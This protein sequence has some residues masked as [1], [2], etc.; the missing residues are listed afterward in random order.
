MSTL[1]STLIQ[2]MRPSFLLLTPACILAGIGAAG[3]EGA[4]DWGLA[5]WVLL[6][7][8]AAHIS[9]NMLNEY[10]D[11]KSGLDLHTARTPFSGG[12]GAL[13]A[14]PEALSA[15][16]WG[17][18]IALLITII[19]GCFLIQLRGWALL[20]PGLLGCAIVLT[21]TQWI[22]KMP[23]LC[24]ITPGLGFGSLMVMGTQLV[25]T[26]H[27]SIP[28][29]LV[30]LVPFFLVNNLLLLNQFPDKDADSRA[31]RRHLLIVYGD[32]AAHRIFALFNLCAFICVISALALYASLPWSLLAI[33]PALPAA[34]ATWRLFH[35]NGDIETLKPA[36]ARNVIVNL[37][38]PTLLGMALLLSR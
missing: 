7:A 36:M 8:I 30:S 6:A 27:Y 19:V 1:T 31:G 35:F 26:G 5:A 24:L 13:P 29:L 14:M 10:F 28:A 11:Y 4:V 3:L 38:T 21:Y 16:G 18:L 37:A 33:L 22:N 23:L 32:S 17:G 25:L 34:G 9:V 2:S 15:V 12:S 20:P